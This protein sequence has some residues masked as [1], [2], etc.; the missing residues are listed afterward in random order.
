MVN[1]L[2]SIMD[3]DEHRIRQEDCNEDTIGIGILTLQTSVLPLIKSKVGLWI[4]QQ[5]WEILYWMYH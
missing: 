4:F 5:L 1:R 3:P 2:K